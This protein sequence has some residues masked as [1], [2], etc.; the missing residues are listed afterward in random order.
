MEQP[1]QLRECADHD[2]DRGGISQA[3]GTAEVA[4]GT[5]SRRRIDTLSITLLPLCPLVPARSPS[6]CWSTPSQ[7]PARVV[8]AE[9]E[10]AA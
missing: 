6:Y 4:A 10:A 8:A 7:A 9:V 5:T 3:P 1:E 2:I